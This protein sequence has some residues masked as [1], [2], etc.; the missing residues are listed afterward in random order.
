VFVPS[1]SVLYQPVGS[2][3]VAVE[4]RCGARQHPKQAATS[5]RTSGILECL[6]P[7]IRVAD[8]TSAE[9]PWV[10]L[11]SVSSLTTWLE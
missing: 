7:T 2:N 9:V 6:C 1:S 10:S 8:K 4:P 11:N 5:E 3:R